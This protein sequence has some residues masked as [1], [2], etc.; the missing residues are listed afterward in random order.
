MYARRA[1]LG[2]IELNDRYFKFVS[3]PH[4]IQ[5]AKKAFINADT[6]NMDQTGFHFKCF[7][8]SDGQGKR[9]DFLVPAVLE[10]SVI[11]ED[12]GEDVEGVGFVRTKVSGL[13]LFDDV[14]DSVEARQ[15]S[16]DAVMCAFSR[17]SRK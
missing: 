3:H 13:R 15:V 17:I 1:F 10:L 16:F 11:D 4:F 12:L 14:H 8:K 2:L 6:N 7:V 9:A 5:A